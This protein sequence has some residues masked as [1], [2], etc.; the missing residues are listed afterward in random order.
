MVVKDGNVWADNP[1]SSEATV[2]HS[3]GTTQIVD[4]GTGN[5]VVV[6]GDGRKPAAS[7]PA[8]AG[9]QPAPADQSSQPSSPAPAVAG[10]PGPTPARPPIAAAA[11]LRP[12]STTPAPAAPPPT[13]P[14]R[15]PSASRSSSTSAG[16]TT[17]AARTTV[18]QGLEGKTVDAACQLVV[19]ARLICA[20]KNLGQAQQGQAPN[21]VT[22]VPRE[23]QTVQVHTP[24]EIDYY[25]TGAPL[26]VPPFSPREDPQT[27]CSTMPAGL[28]CKPNDLQQGN[29]ADQ[30]ISTTPAPGA[31]VP[32]GSTV[33]ANYY[34]T[35]KPIVPPTP[36]RDGA[37]TDPQGYCAFA[38]SLGFECTAPI[39]TNGD[40]GGV[41]GLA[42]PGQPTN[43]VVATDP[44]FSP[45]TGQPYG[46][47][48]TATY[49]TQAGVRVPSV[50]NVPTYSQACSTLI[51]SQLTCGPGSN[52]VAAAGAG[53]A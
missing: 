53:P 36:G 24:V 9:G 48:L 2:I 10:S 21:L 8:P 51:A 32:Y 25:G 5:G 50:D 39:G 31:N 15:P 18:P 52:Q 40:T 46:S 28:K 41:Q 3:N 42:D 12:P 22:A 13:T 26:T 29:P 27:Y 16:S 47:E 17:T 38:D 30:V 34:S 33:L 43:Q 4:K 45:A 44:A 23:G 1:T 11:P 7:R 6:P 35:S 37:P 20:P 19:L 49:F 14:A